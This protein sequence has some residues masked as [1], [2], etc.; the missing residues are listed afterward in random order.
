MEEEVVLHTQ[1][2][3]GSSPCAP[4]I[5]INKLQAASVTTYLSR[6]R[7]AN[8]GQWNLYF[9][10]SG[11][12]RKAKISAQNPPKQERRAPGRSA[13][14]DKAADAAHGLSLRTNDYEAHRDITRL[15]EMR[16]RIAHR[17]EKLDWAD[18]RHVLLAARQVFRWLDDLTT[19]Q[20]HC[21]RLAG[22]LAGFIRLPSASLRSLPDV[23][24][25][26]LR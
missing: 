24:P 4:T 12:R 15:F 1:E 19:A 21:W 6:R 20:P 8:Q 2:A 18:A 17:G 13:L 26:I 14:S 25:D 9:P 3:H 16:N 11:A 5:R 7:S 23:R 10:H 22:C